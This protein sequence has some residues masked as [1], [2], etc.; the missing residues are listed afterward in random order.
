MGETM[1]LRRPGVVTFV[2]VV[3]YIKAV[4]AAVLGIVVLI[5]RNNSGF[6]ANTGQTS[7]ELLVTAIVELGIAVLLLFA[8]AAIMS[9]A[10]WS[11]MLVA[12]VFGARIAV[13]TWWMVAHFG[14]GFQWNAIITVGVGIFVLWAL[15]GHEQSQEFFEG[16][17]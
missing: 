3:M 2:R 6:Q 17:P 15:Y 11:R 16:H 1:T 4:M 8:A 14:G 12:V 13:A 5:E 10:K 9:G 7:D